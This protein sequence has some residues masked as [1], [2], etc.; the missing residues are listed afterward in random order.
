MSYDNELKGALFKNKYK[1][2]PNQPDMTGKC[3]IDG[4]E[5]RISA[6]QNT[7]RSGDEYI[8]MQFQSQEE[9]ERQKRARKKKSDDFDEDVPF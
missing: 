2:R 5:Y 4:V 6:W 7:S 1:E 9:F 3:E 8:S